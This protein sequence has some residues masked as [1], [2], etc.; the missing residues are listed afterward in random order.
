MT[1]NVE[2]TV[3][4]KIARMMLRIAGFAFVDKKTD[5]FVDVFEQNGISVS[6]PTDKQKEKV[7]ALLDKDIRAKVKRVYKIVPHAQK[8]KFEEYV[9]KNN[10]SKDKYKSLWHGSRNQNW[11]SIIINSLQLKPNAIITGKMFGHGIY[12]APSSKKSYN[13]TSLNGTYWAKGTENTA[14]MGLYVTAYGD[15]LDVYQSY[16]YNKNNI[17]GKNCVHAHAGKALLNDEIIYYDEAAMY[18]SYLVEL[19]A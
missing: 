2:I 4:I 15:P 12:F 7:L 19:G 14:Y 10:I 18:L 9:K 17:Q 11:L 13:Y 1:K 3:D 16:Q 8:K 5:N 6:E